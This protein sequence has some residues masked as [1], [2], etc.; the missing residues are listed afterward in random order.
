MGP[1]GVFAAFVLFVVAKSSEAPTPPAKGS[2]TSMSPAKPQKP[3]APYNVILISFDTLRRDFVHAYGYPKRLTPTIDALARRG[4]KFLDA[5]ANCGWTLPQ[6]LTMITGCEPIHH[7][8]VHLQSEN[9]LSPEIPTLAQLFQKAGYMCLGFG[10]WNGYGGSWGHGFSRGMSFYTNL[11]PFNNM[12]EQAVPMVR[13][14]LRIVGKRPFF[15][16]FHTND[17][18]E[19]F[20]PSEPYNSKYGTK[21]VNRYEGQIDYADHYLGVM[22]ED[23]RKLGLGERTLIAFTS[24]HGSEF[25]EHGYLEKK[26]N[27]YDEIMR[28]PLILT[29][30]GVLP[31]GKDVAGFV[32]SA[33][34]APTILDVCS[35]EIPKTMD[36][37]SLAAQIAGS[38]KGVPDVVFAHTKHEMMFYYESFA[39]RTARYKYIRTTPMIKDPEKLEGRGNV[40]QRYE[41]LNRLARQ[42][43]GV[44]LELYD[45][46]KDPGEQ[47][48]VVDEKPA[49]ARDL[50]ARINAWIRRHKFEAVKPLKP[51][52]PDPLPSFQAG[53]R[54]HAQA[55]SRA[56][57]GNPFL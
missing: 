52:D 18:H 8:V 43:G 11:F 9:A 14:T 38:R 22:L 41:R 21:Y 13:E 30:P 42:R 3:E 7:N 32:Q 27:L 36:G 55:A 15:M 51:S 28:V 49:V 23:L 39:A 6:H 4:V 35:I 24:D 1:F 25:E 34:I 44:Y 45:L 19:P 10:N 57:T 37:R 5:Y 50:D 33:D 48:N 56:A 54:A 17:T 53:A 20:A 26:F 31:Q 47:R 2:H 40:G 46:A 16:Y 29:L 12:M